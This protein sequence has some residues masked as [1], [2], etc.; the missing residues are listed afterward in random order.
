M[1][2]AFLATSS[3][4]CAAVSESSGMKVSAR[5]GRRSITASTPSDMA[6]TRLVVEVVGMATA[7]PALAAV[8]P[9]YMLPASRLCRP[10]CLAVQARK[11]ACSSSI[12]SL[13]SSIRGV[14]A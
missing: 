14:G 2:A 7:A 5:H 4:C 9:Q 1:S 12:G 11:S 8:K 10:C 3:H 6:R 13:P